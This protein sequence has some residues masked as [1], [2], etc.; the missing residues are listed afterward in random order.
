MKRNGLMSFATVGVILALAC[1][2]DSP[3]SPSGTVSGTWTGTIM[4]SLLGTGSVRVTLSQSG[5]TISGTWS[6]TFPDP[7]DTTAAR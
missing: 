2:G 7:N 6:A 4:D 1:G 3:M 5:S